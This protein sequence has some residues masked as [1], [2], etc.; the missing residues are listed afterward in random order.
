MQAN[1]IITGMLQSNLELDLNFL[2]QTIINVNII[3][4]PLDG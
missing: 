4:F 2:S 3:S 1:I